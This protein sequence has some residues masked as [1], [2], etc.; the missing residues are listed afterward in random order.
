MLYMCNLSASS[1]CAA[2]RVPSCKAARA[3]VSQSVVRGAL[4]Y[5]LM[6]R[7]LNLLIGYP[8]ASVTAMT[9][10][11]HAWVIQT[12]YIDMYMDSSGLPSMLT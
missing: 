12:V 9:D 5:M 3:D 7:G 4:H 1:G 2:S 10:A 11:V 8:V 6:L